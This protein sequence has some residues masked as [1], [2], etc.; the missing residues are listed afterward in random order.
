MSDF[1]ATGQWAIYS[2]QKTLPYLG[3][4]GA[5]VADD[6]HSYLALVNPSGNIVEEMQGV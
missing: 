6:V 4:A 2:I 5:S 3:E 1:P